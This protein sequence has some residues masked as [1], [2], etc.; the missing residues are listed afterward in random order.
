MSTNARLR[1]V[2]CS[3]PSSRVRGEFRRYAGEGY[4]ARLIT[5]LLSR[6]KQRRNPPLPPVLPVVIA[7]VAFV[8]LLVGISFVIMV[9]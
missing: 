4:G 6:R 3:Q 9:I 1:E 5:A 8:I 7:A 2:L